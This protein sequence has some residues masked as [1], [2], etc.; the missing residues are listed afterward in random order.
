MKYDEM[1]KVLATIASLLADYNYSYYKHEEAAKALVNLH[2]EYCDN[3]NMADDFI[4]LNDEETLSWLLPADNVQAFYAGRMSNNYNPMDKWISLDGYGH[5][6]SYSNSTLIDRRIFFSDLVNWLEGK[7]REEQEE[8]L[9]EI[10]ELA[11]E[12]NN[13]NK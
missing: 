13:K 3:C 7:E 12:Y 6:V 5:L 4:Y 10:M 9:E 8:L 11:K 2:N 1:E